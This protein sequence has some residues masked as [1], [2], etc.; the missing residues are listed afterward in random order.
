[1]LLVSLAQVGNTIFFQ[2]GVEH[3]TVQC[4]NIRPRQLAAAYPVHRRCIPTAPLVRKTRPVDPEPTCRVKR[5]ALTNEAA[6]PVYHRTDNVK[7]EGLD[8]RN[9]ALGHTPS[10]CGCYLCSRLIFRYLMRYY[11]PCRA[12]VKRQ[13]ERGTRM[14]EAHMVTFHLRNGE[15]RTYKGVTRLDT[16]RPH[17]VLV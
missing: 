1:M 5:Q 12:F 10:S 4:V 9:I 17:L 3:H 8:I 2:Q 13:F 7:G 16:S 6:P 14:A 11:K 15:Q